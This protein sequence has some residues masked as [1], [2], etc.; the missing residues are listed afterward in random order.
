ME[1]MREP[2]RCW[3]SLLAFVCMVA[4]CSAQPGMALVF[5]EIM[6]HPIEDPAT[7]DEPLEFIELYN[8]R[9]VSE[10]LGGWAFTN[11]IEYT[12]PA[13]TLLGPKSYLVVARDPNALAAAYD[14]QGVLGPYT[15]KLSNDG[16]RVELSNAAGMIVLSVRY[17][18]S[19]PWPVSADG[20]GHSLILAK[21]GGDPEQAQSWSASSYLAGTPGSA[22]QAQTVSSDPTLVTL[23]DVGSQ[24]RYFKGRQ[25]P[26]PG[27][28]GKPTTAWTQIGFDDAPATT[29]WLDGANGYGYSNSADELQYVGTVL[30]DMS[31]NYIS[32]Y[33]RLRFALSAAQVASLTQLQAE[34]RYDDGYVLYLNG[35]RVGDSGGIVGTPPAYNASGGTA[36]E[37]PAATVD[38]TAFMHLLR[39]GENI[40]AFQVHNATLA[41]S[42]DCFGCVALR[43]TVAQP[44]AGEDPRARVV[45]NEIL[46]NSDAGDGGDWIEL[47]N[48][49]PVAVSLSNVYLSDDRANLLK[50]KIP[51]GAALQPGRFWAVRQGTAPDGF[52]FA[53]DSAGETI[54]V[55]AATDAASP[56]PIRVLDAL[57]YEA[58]DPETTF[59][60]YPDG[61]D[62]LDCL[63][64]GTFGAANAPK[65]IRDVVI[66]EIM[67]HHATRDERYEYVEL[68]NRGSDAVCL[69]G[70]AFT[71]GIEYTFAQNATIA[72]GGYLVVAQDPN[73]LATVYEN[74][75]VGE[76]L[77]G[78]YQGG[79]DDHS[80]RIRLAHPLQRA[81]AANGQD[82]AGMV[83]VDEVTYCDGGRWPAWADGMGASLELRDPGS[84]N[85]TPGAWADS[86]E[87]AKST[88]QEFSFIAPPDDGR[89]T[90]DNPS[91]FDFMLLNAGEVL[92]DD[93]EC[94]FNGVNRLANSGFES[95]DASWR[96]LGNHT[97]SFVTTDDPH[98]GSR[99]LHLIATGH[100]DPGANRI[101]QSISGTSPG[102][103][104]FRGWAKWLRGSR[105]LLLRTTRETSPVRPPRPAHAF[106]LD[107]PL[108]LGTPGR[109]NTAFVANRG[110][111]IREVRHAPV[112]P[113]AGEPILVTARVVDA[114]GID[115]VTLFHRVEGSAS[116]TPLP[117][118]DDGSGEDAIAGDR[119][120]TA[121]IT[122]GTAGQIRAFYI[123][124]SDGVE[125]TRF[126]TPLPPSAEVPTRTCL[127]R[128]AD[129]QQSSRLANYR[130]WMSSDV[131]DAFRSRANLSNELLDCTFVY[132][133]T[134]VFYNCGIRLRGS[135]FLRG[136]SGWTPQT[137]RGL[138]IEFNSDESFRG[139]QEINLD[140]TEGSS[141]GPLQERAS[142][143][144]YAQLGMQH[145]RQE[146]VRLYVNGTR[147]TNFEDVQKV[148]GDYID[149][150]FPGNNE[151]YIHKIDD[152]FEYNADGT[153]H[154]GEAADE[155]LLFDAQHPLM[156]ETYRWHFEKRSHPENDT[157]QHLYELA[158]AL[159]TQSSSTTYERGIEAKLDPRHFTKM[160]ALRH[161]VGDWDSY[162]YTRGKNNAFYFALPE[163]KWYLLPWDIDFTLGSGRGSSSSLFEVTN[164]FPEIIQ[165][166][167]Y[168]KYK[169]MYYDALQ[170]LVDG[171]WKTSYGTADPPT[172][173]DKFLDEGADLLTAEGLG[174]GRRNQIKQFVRD[175]RTFILSQLANQ[176]TQPA[177]RR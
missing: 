120:Y 159:N 112:L 169:Q 83:T 3:C 95:G 70:W 117:M 44:D 151:G 122:G 86:D 136:G 90:H 48:P 51:V 164:E 124:A 62:S 49:G 97:R 37:P 69:A 172:D 36:A 15:G 102:T 99:A 154:S 173:F 143:W 28:D 5:S 23:L 106:Q 123:E 155:G 81:D 93:L 119:I 160:L 84:D 21:L 89:F 25:E 40:L 134:E 64:A 8:N 145:S 146:W 91:I 113:A 148:D 138:R 157:W 162:G 130:I 80:E 150:W 163:G 165:F 168:P 87:S 158:V 132:N 100:G 88:W 94:S 76:N 57:R 19:N 56:A 101:N 167:N 140:W 144:F 24:G 111:D 137:G 34:I 31:G 153:S 43:G 14:I 73:F 50:Y 82:Q 71:D 74:L 79:L 118:V 142:Y 176:P 96:I 30:S 149:A 75:A 22:D 33:A 10:D 1:P 68:Y 2:S 114:D 18:D 156:P 38:L 17:D 166:L 6:Y 52:P 131:M 42:S 171:P 7:G 63:A 12:F 45:V 98:S 174:D 4:F 107:M 139:R 103:V 126:P 29:A 13:G 9:A 65:L 35:V 78:P 53:L 85:D 152:Y 58:L 26:S 115:S 109:Q 61:S 55:T 92:L 104:I 46:A 170:E 133:D 41:G 108:D 105:F 72:P 135:P 59:G 161:A 66:N 20:A 141:R 67:Y 129:V 116:F 77:V 175:R 47:Y 128:V 177:G 11:G 147:L 127:V 54:Y 27:P 39:Q 121:A 16:E 110:P 125:T 60:R 32:I